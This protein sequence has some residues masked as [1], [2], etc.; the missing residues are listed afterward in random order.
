MA[1]A[2]AS[3]IFYSSRI[4]KPSNKL[5]MQNMTVLIVSNTSNLRKMIAKSVK[6]M[7]INHS[8]LLFSNAAQLT[9]FVMLPSGE[10]PVILFMDGEHSSC[11]SDILKI[12]KNRL[13]R[14]L[15]IAVCAA[16][17]NEKN[18]EE[19]FVAGANFYL[20]TE[21][22]FIKLMMVMRKVMRMNVQFFSEHFNRE[23]YFFSY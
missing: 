4:I 19:A 7:K 14:N 21:K 13:F 20:K 9:N 15:S 8:I 12:R 2:F 16:S 6:C 3:A 11:L 22:D 23:T 17:S 1:E 10:D 5:M 18:V